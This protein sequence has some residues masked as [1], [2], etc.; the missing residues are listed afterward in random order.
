MAAMGGAGAALNPDDVL[1]I[2][3]LGSGCEVGRSCHLIRF[4]GKTVMLDCG[5]HPGYSGQAALPFLDFVD[6]DEDEDAEEEFDLEQVDLL[7]VSH[8]HVDHVA[9]LPY[10]TEHTGFKGRVFM[11]H[12]TKAIARLLLTDYV[13]VGGIQTDANMLYNGADVDS[14]LKKAEVTG[15]HQ[16]REVDGIKFW[17][18][19]AGHIL[20]AAMFVIEIAGVKVLYTG[21][22]SREDDHH[23]M[24][25]EIPNFRPDVLICEATFGKT[26]HQPREKRESQF[27]E[28]VENI[29][30]RGGR[31][32]IPMFALGRAQ[33]L[34]LIL[35][36]HW[37]RNERLQEIPVWYASQMSQKA[38]RVFRTYTNVMNNAIRDTAQFRNPFQFDYVRPVGRESFH[39]RGPCVM[40]ASP[41]MMQ[42]G[43]SRRLFEQW[44]TN[45]KNGVIIAGYCVEG[46]LAHKILAP[47]NRQI[48]SS[49]GRTLDVKCDV[50]EAS[51][52]AHADFVGTHSF[53]KALQPTNVVLVHGNKVPI[54]DLH[55]LLVQKFRYR[56]KGKKTVNFQVYSP[57]NQQTV[58]IPFTGQKV[59]KAIGSVAQLALGKKRARGQEGED[60]ADE[61][62]GERRRKM[63][64]RHL[65]GVLVSKNF[66]FH[67]VHPSEISTYTQL[68]TT[69]VIQRLRL[70]FHPTV[71]VLVQC[72]RSLFSDVALGAGGGTQARA[73][74]GGTQLLGNDGS[75]KTR[76][77]VH[78][79]AV[80]VI[81][82]AASALAASAAA[83]GGAAGGGGGGSGSGGSGGSGGGHVCLEWESCPIN[84]MIAD[85]IVAVVMQAEA[86][87][88]V[89]SACDCGV[90]AGA[91]AGA[92]AGADATASLTKDEE[93]LAVVRRL[94]LEFFGGTAS[95]EYVPA[96]SAGDGEELVGKKIRMVVDGKTAI[97]D[98]TT[99]QIEC[100]DPI[101][102]R[103]LK[104]ILNS[105]EN[106]LN[107][108]SPPK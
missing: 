78:G 2:T 48:T 19:N 10:L 32:L 101:R 31:C 25:A 20:G 18:Y 59:V 92:G 51:F 103:H 80:L 96:G 71:A 72:L 65:S 64:G 57:G 15:F 107:S 9:G 44:C 58:P 76:L 73:S 41:G 14:A 98:R 62:E 85:S 6:E 40:L 99:R 91:G 42:S 52:T 38:L 17:C 69:R 75:G 82:V 90:A 45:E 106:S 54:K 95:A 55:K 61:G 34:M 49:R 36:E 93:V 83:A 24:G 27:I 37:R 11:T 84:D 30:L 56:N 104:I 108:L 12:A 63:K 68:R 102:A 53:I 16:E 4:K 35:E 33:E 50:K 5:I 97:F 86:G 23:L 79:G 3:P 87:I 74:P 94:V 29:V 13:R 1:R 88:A 26:V 89:E 8:A 22:Y 60:D 81:H 46:T 105:L 43:Y 47:G 77:F 39:D 67:L 21:D 28:A 100:E 66:N 70:P 7:L